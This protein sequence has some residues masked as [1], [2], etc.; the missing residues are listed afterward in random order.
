VD[1]GLAYQAK[2]F[3]DENA[4]ARLD[5]SNLS[6]DDADGKINFTSNINLNPDLIRYQ[7]G[8]PDT[9]AT[10]VVTAATSSV[11]NTP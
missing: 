10:G 8:L 6:V 5:F 2:V 3:T 9:C 1:S 7:Q 11:K 4:F